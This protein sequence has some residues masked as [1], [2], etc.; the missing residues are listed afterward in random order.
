MAGAVGAGLMAAAAHS[1]SGERVRREGGVRRGGE[2]GNG[3][4]GGG[5]K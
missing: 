5:Y 3:V 4:E 1:G 2:G